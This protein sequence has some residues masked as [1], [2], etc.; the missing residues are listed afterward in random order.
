MVDETTLSTPLD[1]TEPPAVAAYPVAGPLAI[2]RAEPAERT[3][4]I[5]GSGE[6]VVDAAAAGLLH[7]GQPV[8]YAASL[9]ADPASWGRALDAGAD[10]VLTDSNRR[11]A[12]RWGTV[13][14]NGGYT[15]QAGEQPM[16]DDPTDARLPLFPGT[17]DDAMT[18]AQERG[19]AGV[20]A[21]RYGNPV[22]Y[23]PGDR[24]ALSV[25]GD[26]HTAWK[27]RKSVV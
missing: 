3:L 23:A 26:V 15:E 9:D 12:M 17:G 7:A 18:V 11:R 22:S 6:G 10:L 14:E 19:I 20:Q 13:R 24:P 2:V 1:A 21:T 25:D 27:D 5:A 4:V 16:V 8:L